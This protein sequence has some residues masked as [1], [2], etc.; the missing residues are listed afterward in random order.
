MYSIHCILFYNLINALR[1]ATILQWKEK[2]IA[3]QYVYVLLLVDSREVEAF[4]IKIP[5]F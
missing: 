3:L 2:N 4:G 5:P 1:H